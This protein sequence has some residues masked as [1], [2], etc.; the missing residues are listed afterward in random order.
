MVLFLVNS[1]SFLPSMSQL[2]GNWDLRCLACAHFL[3][4][5]HAFLVM[6]LHWNP[7]DSGP[8]YHFIQ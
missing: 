6:I 3:L 5:G 8:W 1:F 4:V 2:E 7:I